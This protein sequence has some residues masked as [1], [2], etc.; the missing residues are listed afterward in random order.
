MV[1]RS[2]TPKRSSSS[3]AK[4]AF[5]RRDVDAARLATLMAADP[6]AA[7]PAHTRRD[8]DPLALRLMT[9]LRADS[10]ADRLLVWRALAP[11]IDEQLDE[12]GR[13]ALDAARLCLD[14]VCAGGVRDPSKPL[15]EREYKAWLDADPQRKASW[16]SVSSVRK[17]LGG[18]WSSV[19]EALG[20]APSATTTAR[21]M[22]AMGKAFGREELRSQL[23][24]C[25]AALSD[26]P[27]RPLDY[28]SQAEHRRWALA[29]MEKPIEERVM[30]R[31]CLQ[32]HSFRKVFGSWPQAIHASGGARTSV[33]S[34][35]ALVR[36]K[37]GAYTANACLAAL[38]LIGPDCCDGQMRWGD[39]RKRAAYLRRVA[40]DEG[41]QVVLPGPQT[42]VN[43]F[44]SWPQALLAAGLIG[45]LECRRRLARV[46][47]TLDDKELVSTFA[48]ALI[49]IGP[50]G[51]RSDY[52][53]LREDRKRANGGRADLP[54]WPTIYQRLGRWEEAVKTATDAHP[55]IVTAWER[56]AATARDAA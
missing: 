12:K 29:E 35:F 4:K 19:Q 13:L 36:A 22:S 23:E 48:E 51:T 2:S 30:P 45:E 3:P 56:H 37:S 52:I 42:I 44:G 46:T 14:D 20:Q 34:S 15:S 25:R 31:L 47:D 26:D 11:F 28:V 5:D 27:D 49:T 50:N 16:P 7:G 1:S 21:R 33:Q 10:R 39:Y 40:M 8:T 6:Q 55:E 18:S 32:P 24:H 43:H 53:E 9:L 38:R 41:R 17:W 54:S